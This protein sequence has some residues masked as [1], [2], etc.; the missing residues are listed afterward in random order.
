VRA[1]EQARRGLERN[2]HDGAQQRLVALSVALRLVESRIPGDPDGA[3]QLLAGAREELSHALGELRELARGIH[4][5][6]LTD[7]GLQPALEALA[8]RAPVPVGIDAPDERLAPDVE[9]AAYYVVAETLTN[10]AKYARAS[11][12]QVRVSRVDGA[13]LVTVSDDGVGGADP[14]RGTGLSGLADRIAVLDG[15]LEVESPA[16]A[17]TT[18]RAAIPMPDDETPSIHS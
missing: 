7:R 15:T 8:A 2:L 9:A 14:A 11:A 12:A 1:E 5:A 10:V 4:P 13:L 3:T 6:V 17:G 16:G 18:I